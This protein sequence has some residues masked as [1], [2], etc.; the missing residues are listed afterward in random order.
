MQA[1][2]RY[3]YYNNQILPSPAYQ[4]DKNLVDETSHAI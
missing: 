2:I 4:A 3:L 1:N